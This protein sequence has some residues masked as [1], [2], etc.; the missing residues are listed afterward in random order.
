MTCRY[1]A[2]TAFMNSNNLKPVGCFEIYHFGNKPIEYIM[3]L[4]NE[5]VFEQL[6]KTNFVA[7]NLL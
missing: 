3:Y 6:Q 5:D 1:P 2:I 4:E 7:A